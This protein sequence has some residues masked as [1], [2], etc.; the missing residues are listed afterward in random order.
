MTKETKRKIPKLFE[1][2][3][4]NTD[5]ISKLKKIDIALNPKSFNKKTT[6][7]QLV[8]KYTL[9]NF[10]RIIFTTVFDN[11]PERFIP[12][13]HVMPIFYSES[14]YDLTYFF[15]KLHYHWKK[16]G[17]SYKLTVQVRGFFYMPYP[18]S[19]FLPLYLDINLVILN[20]SIFH[21]IQHNK[22]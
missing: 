17:N 14:A 6:T 8:E 1:N 4:D 2:V 15:R 18:T 16:I 13:I 21:E 9:D 22:T 7:I 12:Y 11:L 20:K 19:A 3:S 10:D 5:D